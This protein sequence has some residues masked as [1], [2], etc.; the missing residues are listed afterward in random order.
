MTHQEKLSLIKNGMLPKECVP[1]P[2]K[3]LRPI[4]EKRKAEQAA[5]KEA[6]GGESTEL[7]KWYGEKIKQLTGKCIRCGEK[8][9][10]GN[11]KLAI[12]AVAHILPKRENMFPSVATHPENFIE[13]SATCGCHN[14]YDNQANWEEIAQDKIWPVVLEKFLLIE[15]AILERGKIPEVLEQEIPP[16]M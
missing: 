4:S 8:Y 11:E 5:E 14:W 9:N 6:R 7:Q 12:A 10:V 16:K 3:A 2:K 1:K 13:L 15:R